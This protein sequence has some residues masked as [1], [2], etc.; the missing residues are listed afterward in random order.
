MTGPDRPAKDQE[1]LATARKATVYDRRSTERGTRKAP[2]E[3]ADDVLDDDADGS[4]DSATSERTVSGSGSTNVDPTKRPA[5]PRSPAARSADRSAEAGAAGAV[6]KGEDRGDPPDPRPLKAAV[7]EFRLRE[8]LGGGAFGVVY[9]AWDRRLQKPVA[10]KLFAPDGGDRPTLVERILH[11][12]RAVS[13]LDHPNIVRVLRVETAPLSPA[14]RTLLE[15]ERDEHDPP[16]PSGPRAAS[17]SDGGRAGEPGQIDRPSSREVGYIVSELILGG[18]LQEQFNATV[19]GRSPVAPEPKWT[20]PVGA[21][22]FLIPIAEAAGHAHRNGVIHRDLKPAN[23]LL[24]PEGRPMLADFGIA[25]APHRPSADDTLGA[26]AHQTTFLDGS[27]SKTL[28][29]EGRWLGTPAYMAPEQ[30]SQ[31]SADICAATDVWALGVILWELLAGRRMYQG[32]GLEIIDRILREPPPPLPSHVPGPAREVVRTALAFEVADRP[33]DG[34][35][36]ARMLHE[37]ADVLA[38]DAGPHAPPLLRRRAAL[39]GLAAAGTLAAVW[40]VEATRERTAADPATTPELAVD[41]TPEPPPLASV[42][43]ETVP[44]GAEAWLIPIDGYGDPRPDRG[45][46]KAPGVTPASVRAPA[47]WYLLVAR[48]SVVEDGAPANYWHEVERYVAEPPADAPD[49]PA[50]GG[51]DTPYGGGSLSVTLFK[52]SDLGG[53]ALS[54]VPGGEV[55]APRFRPMAEDGPPFDM[56]RYQVPQFYAATRPLED[57]VGEPRV[58]MSYTAAAAALEELGL[59]PPSRAEVAALRKSGAV[60]EAGL[61]LWTASRQP[62]PPG[63]RAE[64]VAPVPFPEY[65]RLV[66]AGGRGSGAAG[67]Q[68]AGSG[69]SGGDL[70]V[71]GVRSDMPRIQAEQ[72][73]RILGDAND[74]DP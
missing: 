7:G 63:M 62:F 51:R 64:D 39:L 8:R 57:E 44:E 36:L 55:S 19:E 15:W 54:T 22:R 21:L 48:K 30:A 43:I 72:F 2:G 50:D 37:A 41:P 61:R 26:P 6:G 3:A 4:R 58:G 29:G 60:D 53:A 73:P 17:E 49:D 71:V 38:P 35:T 40:A 67:D 24:T 32:G 33:K 1:L 28:S 59:R 18:T 45:V 25:R 74:A 69:A 46:I 52:S 70:G 56:V 20:T 65:R 66:I 27:E 11:E 68:L 31:R 12:A 42:Q 13:R 16:L 47:G 34:A 10:V 5:G 14:L 23:V 9:R